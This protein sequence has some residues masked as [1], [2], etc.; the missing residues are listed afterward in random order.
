MFSGYSV[1]PDADLREAR[2]LLR[3]LRESHPRDPK[4]LATAA[5][6]KLC[7]QGDR[8][9]ARRLLKDALQI[10]PND[11]DSAAILGGL[12]CYSGNTDNGLALI[13]GADT[14][15]PSDRRVALWAWRRMACELVD[16]NIDG[17]LSANDDAV[18]RNPNYVGFY[19]SEVVMQ[20][21]KGDR[22][23]ARRA[24]PRARWIDPNYGF[25]RY[26]QT[27]DNVRWPGRLTMS[28]QA[29]NDK[30]RACLQDDYGT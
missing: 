1:D 10:D 22:K 7:L 18:A 27:M 17:A 6:E 24:A 19:R 2:V 15:A 5:A 12:E 26:T 3:K 21:F 20:C 25:E 8:N 16:G 4:V 30:T 28:A 13:R 29:I 14:R 9:E 23:A 11:A